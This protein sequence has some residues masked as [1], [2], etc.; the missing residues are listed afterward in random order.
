MILLALYLTI[1]SFTCLYIQGFNVLSGILHAV[2]CQAAS[3]PNRVPTNPITHIL[4][5]QTWQI[6]I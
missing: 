5:F 2:K 4:D 1:A 3:S 6:L